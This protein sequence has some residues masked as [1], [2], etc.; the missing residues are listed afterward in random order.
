MQAKKIW[1]D[2]L[3]AINAPRNKVRL[4]TEIKNKW[5]DL[6][7]KAKT[8]LSNRKRSKTGGGPKPKEST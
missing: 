1:A 7:K 4:I 8:D 2:I 6:V 5:K 3:K